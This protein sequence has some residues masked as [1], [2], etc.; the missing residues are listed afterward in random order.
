MFA[1]SED[2]SEDELPARKRSRT[3]ESEEPDTTRDIWKT[4]VDPK[5]RASRIIHA[6]QLVVGNGKKLLKPIFEGL[7]DVG[8]VEL[9]YPTNAPPE[10][11]VEGYCYGVNSLLT[12]WQ[13]Q[14]YDGTRERG[15]QGH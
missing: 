7:E 15:F 9:E 14:A 11:Y 3:T 12:R 10:R 8:D 13:V 6:A 1:S 4:K 2:E 5:G